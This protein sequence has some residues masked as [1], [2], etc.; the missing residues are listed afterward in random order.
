M[1][2]R[3]LV[4][5]VAEVGECDVGVKAHHHAVDDVAAPRERPSADLMNLRAAAVILQDDRPSAT[6]VSEA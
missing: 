4:V 1:L 3:V 2:R 5:L 6:L